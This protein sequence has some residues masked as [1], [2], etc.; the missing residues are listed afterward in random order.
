[1]FVQVTRTSRSV[2]TKRRDRTQ[3]FC[4]NI[5][6]IVVN[7]STG[8]MHA[9]PVYRFV[10][11]ASEHSLN[12]S[13]RLVP[14]YNKDYRFTQVA[15]AH[16]SPSS[17]SSHTTQT[18]ILSTSKYSKR[19][20]P[21]LEPAEVRVVHSRERG[22]ATTHAGLAAASLSIYVPREITK[23]PADRHYFSAI[24]P[25]ILIRGVPTAA[26]APCTRRALLLSHST[27]PRTP[28]VENMN[29]TCMNG[30]E[31]NE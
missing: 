14:V 16:E 1:M 29:D 7:Y 4:C 5:I 30:T 27:A 31:S 12:A 11:G 24:H 13:S 9:R 15:S 23:V 26:A 20:R 17:S 28:D 3:Q 25:S 2:H 19:P 10:G 21:N 6:C 8:L 18:T 22:G